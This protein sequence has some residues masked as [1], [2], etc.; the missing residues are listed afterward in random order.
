MSGDM[1]D[2]SPIPI[3][4]LGDALIGDRSHVR[5]AS[6]RAG[7]RERDVDDDRALCALRYQSSHGDKW[8]ERFLALGVAGLAEHRRAPLSSPNETAP[9]IIERMLA[10][11]TRDGWG[12]RKIL[13][14]LE[15]M[16]PSVAW[17]VRSTISDML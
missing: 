16:D 8:R 17:P 13:K 6:L 10:E 3:R 9:P 14:H 12:A 15:T 5:A 4:R 2:S 1:C 11:H 7:S